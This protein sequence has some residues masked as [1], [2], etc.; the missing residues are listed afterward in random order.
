MSLLSFSMIVG[1][2]AVVAGL[3]GSLSGFRDGMI[4]IPFLTLALGVDIR[5]A[6]GASLISLIAVSSEAV[7]RELRNDY[8]NIKLSMVLAA[9]T[10]L[11]AVLGAH[12]AT[13]LSVNAI[14]FLFG[15]TLLSSA[16]AVIGVQ[17]HSSVNLKNLFGNIQSNCRYLYHR[18]S[19]S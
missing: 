11:G 19:S 1:A 5:Y 15:L 7:V 12:L 17:P 13:I 3:L 2:A 14:A 16:C 6:V 18:S 10:T 4:I 8:A 9:G